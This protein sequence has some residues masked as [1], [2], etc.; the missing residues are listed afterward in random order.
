MTQQTT[1]APRLARRG[2][3]RALVRDALNAG[4]TDLGALWRRLEA[5]RTL[6]VHWGYLKRIA[7]DWQRERANG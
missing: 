2:T 1:V 4:E 7:R 3:V 5:D 6:C